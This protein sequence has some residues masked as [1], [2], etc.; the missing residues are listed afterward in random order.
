MEAV[1]LFNLLEQ[2]NSYLLEYHKLNVNEL[3]RLAKRRV[4]N[5]EDF[6]YSRELLLDAISKVDTKISKNKIENLDVNKKQKKRLVS[7]LNLKRKMVMSILDQDLTILSL[8]NELKKGKT[9]DKEII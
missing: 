5:L 2:K 8:V 6:Y 9:Q 3:D 1:S 4:E 7:I